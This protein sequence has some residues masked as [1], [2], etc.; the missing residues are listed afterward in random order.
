MQG[1]FGQSARLRFRAPPEAESTAASLDLE[2][3]K[4]S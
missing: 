4:I 3:S 1:R 2:V